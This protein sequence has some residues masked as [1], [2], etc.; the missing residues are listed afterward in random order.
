M[1]QIIYLNSR[2]ISSDKKQSLKW[3]KNLKTKLS[4]YLKKRHLRESPGA[5]YKSVI[6][7]SIQNKQEL[8]VL[9]S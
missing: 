7:C 9:L 8:T 2:S 1:L 6:W 5:H 4:V 3:L